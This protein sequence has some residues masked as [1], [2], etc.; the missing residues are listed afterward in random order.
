MKKIPHVPHEVHKMQKY[1]P[2]DFVVYKNSIW[3]Q[4][5][6]TWWCREERIRCVRMLPYLNPNLTDKEYEKLLYW[7]L[8]ACFDEKYLKLHSV[9][10]TLLIC[11]FGVALYTGWMT[12]FVLATGSSF[13]YALSMYIGKMRYN[14]EMLSFPVFN[15]EVE[16]EQPKED[17]IQK[18]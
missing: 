10:T 18:L 15:F 8:Q 17:G 7:I 2:S 14:Q 6:G 1:F 12:F 4:S 9:M 16:N 11:L 3:N 5:T 13:G